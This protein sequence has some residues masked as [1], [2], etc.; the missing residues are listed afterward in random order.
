MQINFTNSSPEL[1]Y[2]LAVL[3]KIE[4]SGKTKIK[5]YVSLQAVKAAQEIIMALKHQPELF[6]SN[7]V[8]QLEFTNAR[9]DYLEFSLTDKPTCKVY[10]EYSDNKGYVH[11]SKAMMECTPERVKDLVLLFRNRRYGMIEDI[12]RWADGEV[13]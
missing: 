7:K 13:K 6:I 2:N 3:R 10:L 12:F 4:L 1:S 11:S 8:L 9:D 5:R